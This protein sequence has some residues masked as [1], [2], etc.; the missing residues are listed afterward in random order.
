[1][2]ETLDRIRETIEELFILLLIIGTLGLFLLVLCKRERTD[3]SY[4]HDLF[5]Y[6]EDY[7]KCDYRKHDSKYK[8][9]IKDNH[10]YRIRK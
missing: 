10:H 5:V 8:I 2:E 4:I 7:I 3:N 9:I 1:M 6:L